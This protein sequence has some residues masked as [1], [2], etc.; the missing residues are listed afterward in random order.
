MDSWKSFANSLSGAAATAAAS[1]APVGSK[2]S[3]QWGHLSQQARETLG[4]VDDVTELPAEYR[5][6]EARV[7]GLRSAHA[8][9]TKVAKVFEQEAYDCPVNLQE[10][11]SEASRSLASTVGAWAAQARGVAAAQQSTPPPHR[12]LAHTISR[13][14]ASA[15]VELQ[16]PPT[17][18]GEAAAEVEE[19]EVVRTL[20][21]ALQAV[22]LAS[23]SVGNAR[24]EQ[25]HA[26]VDNFLTPWVAFGNQVNLSTKARQ[27]VSNARLELDVAKQTL[28]SVETTH[29]PG[30]TDPSKL[31]KAQSD[32]ENAEDA[33]VAATEDA[34][35]LMK[36][37]LE[38]PEPVRMLSVLVQVYVFTTITTAAAL[39]YAI[40][41]EGDRK[42]KKLTLCD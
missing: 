3:K 33:L 36:N 32:V 15:A 25:D 37:C 30:S 8:S 29:P 2:L 13:S 42:Q 22:S 7:D 9:V 23:N 4:A 26:I 6:L 14:A 16:R 35:G 5:A 40:C 27:A 11:V 12:T 19:R 1:A 24:L 39:W 41:V 28:K 34:I 31:Q 17:S 38:N 18:S 10:S 21:S 20:S